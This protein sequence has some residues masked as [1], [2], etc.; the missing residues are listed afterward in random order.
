MK[1]RHTYTFSYDKTRLIQHS[2]T[3]QEYEDHLEIV[4]S[5]DPWNVL[6][7]PI[8]VNQ[9]QESRRKEIAN[10]IHNFLIEG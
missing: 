7:Y 1:L 9:D 6:G 10:I 4:D 2:I 5:Y 3:I 8:D